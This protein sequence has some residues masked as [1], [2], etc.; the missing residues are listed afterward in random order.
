MLGHQSSQAA[1]IH[2]LKYLGRLSLTRLRFFSPQAQSEVEIFGEI[3][4]NYDLL[5]HQNFYIWQLENELLKVS[6]LL[7]NDSRIHRNMKI[8]RDR[9]VKLGCCDFHSTQP[10]G[11]QS[12]LLFFPSKGG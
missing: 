2:K 4:P 1:M 11:Y 9:A 3:R 10:K 7:M 12:K 5:K 6:V 8:A